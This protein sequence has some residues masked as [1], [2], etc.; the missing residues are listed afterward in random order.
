MII[1]Q[2]SLDAYRLFRQLDNEKRFVGSAQE[3]S[4]VSQGNQADGFSHGLSCFMKECKRE[5]VV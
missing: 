5:K 1:E 2:F 4:E 3:Q